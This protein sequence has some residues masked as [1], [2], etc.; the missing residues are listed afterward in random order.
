MKIGYQGNWIGLERVIRRGALAF[1]LAGS[2]IGCNDDEHQDDPREVSNEDTALLGSEL[3]T[4]AEQDLQEMQALGMGI[5]VQLADGRLVEVAAGRIGPNATDP[6]YDVGATR[7]ILGSVTKLYTATMIMQLVEEGSLS[8]DDTLE[9]WF[10]I[11]KADAIT[12]RMLLSHTSGLRECLEALTQEETAQ[13]WTP[14][15]L[16]D[17]AVALGPWAEPGGNVARYANT[18]FLVLAMLLEKLTGTSW[19]QNVHTRITTPLGL[20]HTGSATEPG[21]RGDLVEG[22]LH[23]EETGWTAALALTDPSVGWGYGAMAATNRELA[24]FTKALF[25]GE[26]FESPSTL[27][28]MRQFDAEIDPTLLSDG[29]PPYRV[30]LG[31]VRYEI[32]DLQLEGH[33]GHVVGFNSA[34]FHDPAT[35]SLISVTSNDEDEVAGLTA[36]KVAQHLRSR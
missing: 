33:V 12:V 10:S 35:G 9:P 21:G 11:P 18:N 22:W 30:G 6:L 13:P 25:A 31:M 29:E 16:L 3:R 5:T 28:Q 26:L 24:R 7:Q 4:L 36:V 17:K 15:Q 27:A 23:T 20:V 19:E 32:D 1:V 8:L 2:A 34:T 14:M